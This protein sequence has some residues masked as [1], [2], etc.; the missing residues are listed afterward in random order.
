MMNAMLV[1]AAM[2][3][4]QGAPKPLIDNARVT[5]WE[6]TPPA[7]EFANDTVTVTSSGEVRYYKKDS[8]AVAAKLVIGLKPGKVAPLANTSGFPLA[9][10]RPGA[11]KI[12]DNERVT[13]WDYTW[14]LGKPTPMHFHDKDVVVMFLEEGDLKSTTAKGEV[15]LNQ[16]KP[17]TIR[18]NARDRV[19]TE[20][21]V[22]GK[23]RA[24][25]VELK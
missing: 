3:M 1:T 19:H 8:L 17:G 13:A 2:L 15:T 4:F 16:Y 18:F 6:Q 21:L 10:P 25:I 23:Q 20:E 5:V 22:R 9:M 7:G 24:I 14:T 11:K 12:L